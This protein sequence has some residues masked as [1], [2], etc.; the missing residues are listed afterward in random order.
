[1]ETGNLGN[2]HPVLRRASVLLAVFVHYRF[3]KL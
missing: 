2:G 3:L 1:M